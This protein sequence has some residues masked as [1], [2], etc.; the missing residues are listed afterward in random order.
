MPNFNN[1]SLIVLPGNGDYRCIIESVNGCFSDS[2]NLVRISSAGLGDKS[3]L[4]SVK[5]YPNPSATCSFFIDTE[6][7]ERR[8]KEVKMWDALGGEIPLKQNERPSENAIW[9]VEA[10]GSVPGVYYVLIMFS[11][12]SIQTTNVIFS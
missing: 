6:A 3:L 10:P 9:R 12:G 7:S 2:S 1:F 11:D 8:I 5:L 4:S